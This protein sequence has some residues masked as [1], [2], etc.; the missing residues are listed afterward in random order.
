M[1]FR[2]AILIIH[3]FA[4]G[5]Y[6]QEDL[7]N[8]LEL[9][10]NFDVYQFT[11]P[12][13][14]RNLS[15]VNYQ[16]WIKA[17]E[18]KMS[19]LI[20]NGYDNIYLIGHSMGGVIA[21]YLA[22]KYKQVKKLVLAAPSFHY[23]NAVK[24]D[25]NIKDSIKVA[26]KVIEQYD[27]EEIV[28]KFLKLNITTIKEFITLVKEYYAYPKNISCPVLLLHGSN[29]HLVPK[30]SVE[31][32]YNE[33]NKNIK[34]VIYISGVNHEVFKNSRQEEIF[35]LVEDFLKYKQNGGI[36]NI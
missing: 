24:D 35:K 34:K 21:S 16:E 17:C 23:F 10:S 3:G 15:K 25:L 36:Y 18:D 5:T 8:Y 6:D 32:V 33:L 12:G 14:S 22:T 29:D 9:N 11:L 4:G 26:P 31:Y 19:W 28:G 13:Q 2:K 27:K 30:T 20:K 7:A 1:I